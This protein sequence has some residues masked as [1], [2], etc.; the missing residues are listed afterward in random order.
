M[1]TFIP[2]PIGNLQD[3]TFRTLEVLKSAEIVFCEDTRVAKQLIKLLQERFG[4]KFGNFEFISFHEHNQLKRLQEFGDKIKEKNCVYMSDAGMP[5]ISDP[6]ALLAK[7][8]QENSIDYDFLPGASAAPLVYA[9][10]GFESGKFCFY[11]FLPQ[12]GKARS[13][14]LLNILNSAF[15][16]VIYEAPHRIIKLLEEICQTDPQR[17]LFAA[18]ELTKKHQKFYRLTAKELHKQLQKDSTKGE[19]ALVIKGKTEKSQKIDI[20]ELL[21]L[22]LPPKTKAKLI[23]KLTGKTVKECYEEVTKKK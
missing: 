11:G 17:E 8:C 23:A 2:T 3:I 19:W 21:K 15:D 14:E 1:L 13:E 7:Y 20:Q 4:A 18:K 10:S 12:K 16:T 22:N 9:A 6:G 5:G